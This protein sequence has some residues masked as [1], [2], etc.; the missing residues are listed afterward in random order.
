MQLEQALTTRILL[1]EHHPLHRAVFYG[2]LFIGIG[3]V[4]VILSLSVL[5][6]GM[7]WMED[8]LFPVHIPLWVIGVLCGTGVGGGVWLIVS[9]LRDVQRIWNRNHGQQ[10]FPSSPWLW[11]YPWQAWGVTDNFLKSALRSLVA[12]IL[13]SLFLSPFHWIA[14]AWEERSFFWQGIVGLLDLVIILSVGDRF[15]MKLKQYLRYGNSQL[16]FHDFPFFLGNPLSLTLKNVPST[17]STLHLTLR[18]I[19]EAYLSDN[20]SQ[21]TQ[22]VVVCYQ[23]Y[24]DSQMIEQGDVH[25]GADLDLLWMLPEDPT[26]SSTPSERPATYWELEVTAEQQDVNYQSRF[27]LPIYAEPVEFT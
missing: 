24:Q 11:D 20:T 25:A 14:F 13:F 23:I 26:L 12:L 6:I 19:E 5:F 18:C 16:E 27:L 15:V 10:Q 2:K 22:S 8:S 7:R 4:F 1:K 17:I 3:L 9:G 21:N